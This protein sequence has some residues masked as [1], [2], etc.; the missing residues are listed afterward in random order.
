M[1]LL[2]AA[3]VGHARAR[4]GRQADEQLADGRS[5]EGWAPIVVEIA[6]IG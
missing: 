3:V 5:I 4:V 1:C 6:V 2:H